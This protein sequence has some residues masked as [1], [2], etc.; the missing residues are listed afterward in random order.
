MVASFATIKSSGY[1]TRQSEAV[2]YY[3]NEEATGIWLRGHQALGIAAGDAVTADDFDR[4][5]AGLDPSGK[6]LSKPTGAG[7]MLGVDITLSAPKGFSAMF[8]VADR[9]LRRSLAEAERFAVESS[10]RMID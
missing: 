10:V 1:Y 2:S 5:C 8:A 4:I 7:R 6:P 3:A 9:Q